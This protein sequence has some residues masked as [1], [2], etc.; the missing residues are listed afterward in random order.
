LL[1]E[2]DGDY[3]HANPDVYTEGDL[4]SMQ[5]RNVKNDEFKDTLANG[6]GYV[7][8]RVWE[9]DLAKKYEEVKDSIKKQIG[10]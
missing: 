8:T 3:F 1:I 5:K 9:S 2:V 6:R 4:N 10:L 7:L